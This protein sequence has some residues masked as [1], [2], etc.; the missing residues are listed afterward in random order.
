[1][2]VGANVRLTW[3]NIAFVK[4]FKLILHP[5]VTKKKVFNIYTSHCNIRSWFI[6]KIS[7]E[8]A[9]ICV[10]CLQFCKVHITI[11]KSN[12]EKWYSIVGNCSLIPREGR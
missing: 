11:G 7:A 9:V 4:H 3:G 5:S 1:M 2:P 8:D 10:L 6:F 12:F